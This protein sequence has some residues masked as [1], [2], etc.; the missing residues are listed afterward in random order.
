VGREILFAP[1]L[2]GQAALPRERA[3]V[4]DALHR[5]IVIGEPWRRPA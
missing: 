1:L 5:W 4:V 2:T 3:F